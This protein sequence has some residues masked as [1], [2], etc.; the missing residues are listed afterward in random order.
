MYGPDLSGKRVAIYA[1]Y[2][3]SNQREAS[4]EDQV[5][6]C[7]EFIERNGG[8]VRDDLVFFDKA[9]SGASLERPGFEQMMGQVSARPLRVDV[10]VSEDL[11]RITRDFADGAT[12][13]KRLQY[14]GVPLISVADGINTST[15][16]A[17]MTFAM[18]SLMG[19]MY[20]EG[21]RDKTL[22]GLEGRALAGL[23]TGGL[24]IGYRSEPVTDP[25]NR[26]IGHRIVIDEA[27]AATVRR[28]F[29]LY[30]GGLSHEAIARTLSAEKVP[31]PRAN[32]LHRRHGWVSSSVRAILRNKTYTGEFAFKTKQWVKVPGTNIRRYRHRPESEVMRRS[33]PE[34]RIV[35]A[36][37]WEEARARLAAVASFYTRTVDGQP[38]GRARAGKATTYPF[39]GLLRCA[40][41][42]APM[43]ISG[44]SSQKYYSCSDAKKR[45]TCANRLSL[46]E[47][48]ART[49]MLRL[50][51]ELLTTPKEV[52]FIRKATAE[53][54]GE[55][56]RKVNADVDE[57]R[58]R[59]QRTV[60][61]M[62]GLV[63]FIADGDHSEYIRT[64]LK[65]L[66]AQATAEKRAIAELLERGSGAVRL[67]SPEQ[68]VERAVLFET[69]LLKDPTRGREELRRMFEGEQVLVRP[70]PEGFYIAEGKLLPLALFSLRLDSTEAETAK[71]RDSEESAGLPANRQSRGLPPSCSTVSCAGRI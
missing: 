45:G 7:T 51:R 19:D 31:P 60:Q 69:L 40:E 33:Q 28:I 11:S 23:S 68:T 18:T 24:P 63:T 15:P 66:E 9:V 3:S 36:D 8:T 4:I 10:I 2:S 34:L 44:G 27:A 41:C 49:S 29:E 35:D 13:F 71:A 52:A 67:P 38:K 62:A 22:R 32:S 12:I 39:S 37:T 14:L 61:R 64:T 55:M 1:R 26:V 17:K 42:C 20:I 56:G 30:T 43:C 70:Q 6:R 47:D 54:L 48:I 58:Q 5:R 57:R 53:L 46:R 25:L 65:D 16:N 21:L 59:L 50:M